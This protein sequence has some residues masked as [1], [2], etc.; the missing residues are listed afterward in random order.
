M[1]WKIPQVFEIIKSI[2]NDFELNDAYR[3]MLHIKLSM[4]RFLAL[5]L[6]EVRRAY[7]LDTIGHVGVPFAA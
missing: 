4:L 2:A 3:N 5:L 7:M 6:S 1:A